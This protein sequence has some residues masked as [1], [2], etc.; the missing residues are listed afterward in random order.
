MNT[1]TL[2]QIFSK[3]SKA[4]PTPQSDL[5]YV[6]HYTLLV[7]VVLSAQS[8]DAQ[9]NKATKDDLTLHYAGKKN[10]FAKFLSPQRR[11]KLKKIIE[12]YKSR[13]S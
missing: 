11:L 7:A 5:Q 1:S 8:T 9:V 6:N 2:N 3:L 10:T 13:L 4:I 12:R